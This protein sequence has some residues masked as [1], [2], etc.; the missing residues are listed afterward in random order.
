MQVSCAFKFLRV[1]EHAPTLVDDNIR[2]TLTLATSVTGVSKIHTVRNTVQL[3]VILKYGSL[4]IF[5]AVESGH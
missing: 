5:K 4:L 2:D 1:R 3:T